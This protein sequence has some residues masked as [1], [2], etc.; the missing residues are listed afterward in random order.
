[1]EWLINLIKK[2]S[3]NAYN[4]NFVVKDNNI[5]IS[6]NHRTALWCWMQHLTL[7]DSIAV[8]HIDRH[9]DTLNLNEAYIK[10][11]PGLF[12]LKGIKDYLD[13]NVI[14]GR[15]KTPLIRWDN[16]LSYFI[17]AGELKNNIECIYL[18]THKEGDKPQNPHGHC[19]KNVEMYE[20]LRGLNDAIDNHE[21]LIVNI[22]I[23]YFFTSHQENYFRFI[24]DAL[25]SE[26]FKLVKYGIDNNKIT[27]LTMCLSPECCG[28]GD[29]NW[30]NS[31]QVLE[32]ATRELGIK[33]DLK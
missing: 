9:Y 30:S 4:V 21:K 1:M 28:G 6:D 8:F 22:D 14:I 27:C 19:I 11:F 18:A 3:S 20:L 12:N 24:D 13:L 32:I 17:V 29:G 16:Y 7:N 2:G 15:D 26:L 33:I 10:E 25:I 23:D 31:E 5:Y